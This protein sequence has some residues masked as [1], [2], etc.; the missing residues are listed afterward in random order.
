M[1]QIKEAASRKA[2]GGRDL[3]PPEPDASILSGCS[4]KAAIEW[5]H[6]LAQ[7]ASQEQVG[8]SLLCVL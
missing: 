7:G 3:R 8:V 1:S 6:V 5:L 4:A 2:V